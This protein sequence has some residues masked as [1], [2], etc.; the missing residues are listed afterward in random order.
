MPKT[1][2]LLLG[3]R[4]LIL[5]FTIGIR[6]PT[7]AAIFGVDYVTLGLVSLQFDLCFFVADASTKL[8]EVYVYE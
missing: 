7:L 2:P 8:Y 3:L 1:H 5:R 4:V 6:P